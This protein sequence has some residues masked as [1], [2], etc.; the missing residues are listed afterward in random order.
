[1]GQSGKL[2]HTLDVRAQLVNIVLSAF[3]TA[4]FVGP[5]C[6]FCARHLEVGWICGFCVAGALSMF[7]PR[8]VIQRLAW[9]SD[10]AVYR[11]LRVPLVIQVTQDAGWLRRVSRKSRRR[12]RRSTQALTQIQRD[13][14][15]RERF[16]LGL[17]AFYILC[18]I[19]AL[20]Q[21]QL[22][23]CLVLMFANVFYNLYPIWVQQYLRLRVSRC[24]ARSN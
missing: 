6:I 14:W 2:I 5:V 7:L 8:A 21:G 19:A 22:W 11:R 13:T 15:M 23:W 17:L 20:C 18:S 4:I 3:W 16:H 10:P 24:L 12:V 9:S 1:M